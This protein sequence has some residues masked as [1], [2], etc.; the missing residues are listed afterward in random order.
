[1]HVCIPITFVPPGSGCIGYGYQAVMGG[2]T[3]CTEGSCGYGGNPGTPYGVCSAAAALGGSCS[4]GVCLAPG[5]CGP[6]RVCALPDGAYC[7]DPAPGTAPGTVLLFLPPF[8]GAITNLAADG[9]HVFFAFNAS[10]YSVTVDGS[11]TT[12][13][14]PLGN[15]VSLTASGGYLYWIDINSTIRRM[16]VDGGAIDDLYKGSGTPL[17]TI[18]VDG[19]G[20]LFESADPRNPG[21]QAIV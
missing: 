1:M 10:L 16:P 7:D 14:V 2:A 21:G 19:A 15:Y 13:L 20:V 18:A 4:G 9:S 5:M 3:Y 17:I 8:S 6:G 11:A 12:M